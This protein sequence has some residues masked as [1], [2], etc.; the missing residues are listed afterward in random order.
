[1]YILFVHH[2]L[3]LHL[4]IKKFLLSISLQLLTTVICFILLPLAFFHFRL[5]FFHFHSIFFTSV[6]VRLHFST[7]RRGL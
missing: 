7:T 1:M 6:C 3:F 4:I 5:I 2:V